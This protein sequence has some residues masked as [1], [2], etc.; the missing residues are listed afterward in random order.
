[1]TQNKIKF[2]VCGTDTDVGKTIVSSLFVVGLNAKYWKPIQSG[3]DDGSDSE[4]ILSSLSLT[5]E[6]IIP[7]IYKFKA[8]VSPHWAAEKEGKLI[9]IEQ[10][11]LPSIDSNLVVE[12]AGGVLV[13]LTRNYL[14]ID[15]IK[16]FDL[17]VILVARSGL[18]TINHTLLT[19]ETL[20]RKNIKIIGIILNGKLHEDNPKTIENFTNV[21]VL[22][23]LPFL[24]RVSSSSLL[25]FWEEQNL[26]RKLNNFF[27]L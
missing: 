5:K 19:I 18:G 27:K 10:L 1:M 14:Q 25:N 23:Q 16:K 3:M 20:R 8:P 17:P 4:K 6:R 15:L 7:E 22:A 2:I 12:T 24:Q 26:K 13:P 9:K 11:I 21:K